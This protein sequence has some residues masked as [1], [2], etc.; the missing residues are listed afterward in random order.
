MLSSGSLQQTDA[1]L[2]AGFH[3][4]LIPDAGLDYADMAAAHHQHTQT[5]LADTAAD[6]QRQ[7]I[8]QE[9]LV[10]GEVTAIIAAGFI[11]LTVQGLCDDTDAHGGKHQRPAK[12]FIPEENI[13]V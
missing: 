4:G 3:G 1:C 2:F 5:A 6:G 7:L 10:E 9:H 11:Q 8:V 12:Y 13:A